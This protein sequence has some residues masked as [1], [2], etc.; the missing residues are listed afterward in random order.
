MGRPA[1]D[2]EQFSE[3]VGTI[4]DAAI[5]PHQWPTAIEQIAR[6]IE[7]VNGVILM[8]DTVEG[9]AKFHVNWNVNPDDMRVY[10]ES[11]HADNPLDGVFNRFDVDE[12]Y[13][14]AMVMDEK[15]WL[16]TRIYREFGRPRGFLDSIGVSLLKTPSRLASLSIARDHDAG[17]AGPRELEIMRL[18][19]P[20]V[21][22]SVSIADL[23]EMRELTVRTFESAFDSLRVPVVFVDTVCRIVH[24]NAAAREM[25][26][27][28]GPIRS[29]S[30]VLKA[31]TADA[32][33]ALE[34]AIAAGGDGVDG[35]RVVFTPYADG[36][37][38][39]AHLLPMRSG[40]VRG[41][42][43]PAASTAV[44]V[45]PGADPGALPLD[46]WGSAYGITA[47]E[48]RVLELLVEGASVTEAAERLNVEITTART[49]LARLMQ[50]TGTNRQADLVRLAIQLMPPVRRAGA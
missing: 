21:R 18:L 44:F 43:E 3:V 12:P 34:R 16:A 26:A 10:S 1:I 37:V 49:H 38:A 50:K 15:E 2:T 42:I 48:L 30:N 41:R 19:A 33:R 24:A 14:I 23:I 31:Q 32:S 25:F 47:G 4:Y 46:I 29:D 8:L 36:R 45:T 40:P 11:F 20:H 28:G 35:G 39:F 9:R 17:F 13:S 7:G 27:S 22:R 6:M 5:D